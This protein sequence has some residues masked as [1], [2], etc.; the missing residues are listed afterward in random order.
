MW[1]VNDWPAGVASV[2]RY[3]REQ[4]GDMQW[5]VRSTG[6]GVKAEEFARELSARVGKPVWLDGWNRSVT[7]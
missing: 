3:R 4:D 6:D 5:M 1:D 2:G 7:A